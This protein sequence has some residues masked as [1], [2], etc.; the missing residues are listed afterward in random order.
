MNRRELSQKKNIEQFY[1]NNHSDN[2]LV[3]WYNDEGFF[4]Y[5]TTIKQSRVVCF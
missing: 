2:L 5:E 1:Q 4:C 3:I